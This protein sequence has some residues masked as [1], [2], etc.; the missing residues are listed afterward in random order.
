MLIFPVLQAIAKRVLRRPQ[1]W[2]WQG[3]I[4][5]YMNYMQKSEGF[6]IAVGIA[7]GVPIGLMLDNVAAGIAIGLAMAIAAGMVLKR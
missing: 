1:G 5:N 2:G 6:G 4:A 3:R 7:L